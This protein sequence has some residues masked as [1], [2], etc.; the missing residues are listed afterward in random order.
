MS[1]STFYSHIEGQFARP[2]HLR[3]CMPLNAPGVGLQFVSYS[4]CLMGPLICVFVVEFVSS[5]KLWT[6]QEQRVSSL[7]RGCAIAMHDAVHNAALL[8]N[9]KWETGSAKL[10]ATANKQTNHFRA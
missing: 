9:G 8:E 5:R 4:R 10:C 2:Q 7:Y 1:L 6:C 3:H